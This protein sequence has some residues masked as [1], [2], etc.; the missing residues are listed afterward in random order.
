[1]FH[2]IDL[3]IVGAGPVGCVIAERA[4]TQRGW[5]SLIIEK[6]NHIAGNCHDRFHESGILI[7]QYGP[8]YF[9][10]NNSHLLHYLSKFTEWIPGNYIVKSFSQGQLYPFPINLTTLEQ[11]FNRKLSMDEAKSLLE[12]LRSQ[13][14]QPINSEEFVLS[15]VGRELYE[16][17]YLGYTLKQWEQHPQDLAP[18]VCGRIP[19]RLNRDERYVDHRFQVTPKHGFTRMFENMIKHE[20][21]HVRLNTDYSN[22]RNW[23]RPRVGTVFCGPVD[24]YFN[25]KYG[26]LPW[27]SLD[28]E[29][30]A[31][32]KEFV[33]PCV[34]INYPNDFLYTR[35]VEI[36]HV[37][38]QEH[39]H[40]V[41]SYEYSK[42]EGDPYYPV[43]AESNQALFRKYKLLAENEQ[44]TRR[45]YFAGRLAQ[46]R[47]MNTDEALEDGLSTFQK[48]S[49]EVNYANSSQYPQQSVVG[50][51]AS[52]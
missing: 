21:I 12:N 47:Y 13:I 14:D 11:F 29:F 34:Q 35:S 33:Q 15:R 20:K 7:H 2:D 40:T 51:H 22:I 5:R 6:R 45:V 41:V 1:M 42:S 31:F 9:R 52:L 16:A 28:F 24:E 17:F 19:V 23:L 27:R 4:A 46:Y 44:R 38:R 48:I 39:C 18:S 43:P 50:H 30:K 26:K 32:Q 10:T 8:H 49:E 3:V 37:T 25:H 36:K